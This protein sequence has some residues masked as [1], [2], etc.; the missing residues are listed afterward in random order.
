MA[1]LD[2]RGYVRRQPFVPFRL[3][4][5]DGSTYDI[6][7]P[8]L[9][10]VGPATVIVGDPGPTRTTPAVDVHLVDAFHIV[11]IIPLARRD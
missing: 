7:H 9:C 6:I 8:E 2:I 11:K 10:L 5:S 3:V 4:V 1:P